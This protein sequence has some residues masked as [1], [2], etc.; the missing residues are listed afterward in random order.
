[1]TKTENEGAERPPYAC[2]TRHDVAGDTSS[3][4]THNSR[5]TS[6]KT[7]HIDGSLVRPRDRRYTSRL[8]KCEAPSV[9]VF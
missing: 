7:D 4:T 5:T 3:N 9:T 8:S 1:M 6:G 2:F